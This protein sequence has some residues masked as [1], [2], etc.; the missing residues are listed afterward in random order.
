LS[1]ANLTQNDVTLKDKE[2]FADKINLK[3]SK[4][5]DSPDY[6]GGPSVITRINESGRRAVTVREGTVTTETEAYKF[7]F[8]ISQESN[9][10]FC[11]F[12]AHTFLCIPFL[13]F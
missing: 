9:L 4:W 5:G 8:F 13:S 11:D 7:G 3:T 2:D 12:E 10:L 6:L 1:Q